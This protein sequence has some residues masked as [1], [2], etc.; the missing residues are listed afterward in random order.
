MILSGG[1]GKRAERKKG[2]HIIEALFKKKLKA[3]E[4]Q[5]IH[6]ENCNQSSRHE[7][8]N[9]ISSFI[10]V[11]NIYYELLKFFFSRDWKFF[12]VFSLFVLYLIFK[13]VK[14][15]WQHCLIVWPFEIQHVL[16]CIKSGYPGSQMIKHTLDQKLC[17]LRCQDTIS[18]IILIIEVGSLNSL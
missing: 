18:H 5:S 1:M 11:I 2:A 17:V 9:K 13:H 14:V 4:K 12:H 16:C 3:K 8:F 15:Y 7:P 6:S 10:I